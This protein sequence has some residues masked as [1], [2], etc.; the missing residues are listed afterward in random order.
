MIHA[1]KPSNRLH[2]AR[3]G[4]MTAA[5]GGRLQLVAIAAVTDQTA[6]PVAFTLDAYSGGVMFPELSPSVNW[7][8]PVVVDLEGLTAP[9]T[10]PVHRD[11]DTTRPIGHATPDVSGGRVVAPGILS[12]PG[13]DTDE[14]IQSARAGFPWRASIGTSEMTF[15]R[16]AAGRSVNVNGRNFDGPILVVRR[17]HLDEIS[18]VSVPGDFDTYAAIAANRGSDSHSQQSATEGS[19]MGFIA[20]LKAN[21]HDVNALTQEEMQ[22]LHAEYTAEVAADEVATDAADD[23]ATADDEAATATASRARTQTPPVRTDSTQQSR[24]QLRAALADEED[25]VAA[26][27]VIGETIGNPEMSGGSRLT[28][29]AIREGW[30][31]AQTTLAAR[32]G[33]RP[34]APAIHTTGPA[35]RCTV[36][37]LQGALLLRAG[38]SIDRVMPQSQY[39]PAWLSRPVNDP[40]RD[41]IMN[42]AHEFRSGTLM[43][44]VQRSLLAAGRDCP[45]MDD[46]HA[47]LQAAFSTNSVQ[48]VFDQSVGSIALMAYAESGN[49]AQGWTSESDSLNLL[50]HERP[51]MQ[52]AGDLTKHVTG[53][54]AN[55]VSREANSETI[56]VDRYSNQCTIDENDFINDNFGLL[57]ETPRDFGRAA[58]R[59]V[60][61][62]VAA[63]LL[64]N[65]NLSR[66][67]RALFNATDKSLLTGSALT[68]A[69]LQAARAQ[70]ARM[71]DGTASLNLPATHLIVPSTLGDTAVQLVMSAVLTN[72]SGGG[73]MNPIF[74]R[75]IA[76]V[77]EAR[78]ANGV[79]DPRTAAALAGSLT[80]W[81]L[82]SAEGR[83][84]EIQYLQGTG[85]QPIV[86]VTPLA[87]TGEFGMNISVKHYAGAAPLDHSSMIRNDA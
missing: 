30:T 12:V 56:Q 76:P 68:R 64:A 61:T 43:S 19:E 47:V 84:I 69:T 20:W 53:D 22:A 49:F 52:A 2:A 6:G 63:V 82:V 73:G 13:S 24:A 79:T 85:R 28:A 83:T 32:R 70:L 48:A 23:D 3:P 8:G 86:L 87:G 7:R 80:S 14:I 11:H 42:A 38:R 41:Q 25:R 54:T 39:S 65:G 21:G 4:L 31:V 71:M 77:E 16:V 75:N 15:E 26:I 35:Q 45:N 5:A 18:I 62:L 34:A 33:S 9:D 60:P 78:L 50:P 67:G 59:L 17:A 46:R 57:A 51:R 37:A 29:H 66:T 27:R 10:V 58:A 36:E 40:Q 72:D 55:H 1:G 44:F 81:Y 74:N